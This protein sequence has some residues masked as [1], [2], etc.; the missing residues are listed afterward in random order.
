MVYVGELCLNIEMKDKE[1]LE[2][3]IIKLGKDKLED[4]LEN[5]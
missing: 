4:N 2:I 3:S 1:N 5:K